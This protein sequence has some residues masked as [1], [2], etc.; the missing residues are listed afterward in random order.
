MYAA[1][2][3]DGLVIFRSQANILHTH[4]STTTA[5]SSENHTINRT[6]PLGVT[7]IPQDPWWIRLLNET[8]E[9][10]LSSSEASNDNFN[11]GIR[12]RVKMANKTTDT[13]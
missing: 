1:I 4:N 3:P 12:V 10:S 13:Q 9:D 2:H 7:V 8:K 5:N 6:S 11:L